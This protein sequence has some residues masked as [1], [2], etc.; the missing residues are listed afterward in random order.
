MLALSALFFGG[1]L[2]AVAAAAAV[3]AAVVAL[4][5]A[6]GRDDGTGPEEVEVPRAQEPP[7]SPET[8]TDIGMCVSLALALTMVVCTA[9]CVS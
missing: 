7:S 6:G 5:E 4:E 9:A 3:A 2:S 8:P 1:P